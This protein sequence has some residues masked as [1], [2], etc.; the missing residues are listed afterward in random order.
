MSIVA[1]KIDGEKITLAGDT[2]S[3]WGVHKLPKADYSD[4][5]VKCFGKIFQVNDMTIGC[6]GSVADIGLLRLYCK[7]HRPKEMERDYVLDWF[8]E[9]RDWANSKYKVNINDLSIHGILVYNKKAYTF[10]DFLDVVEVKSCDAVGSGMW[11][12][13]GAMFTGASAEEAVKAAIRYDMYCGGDV[14]KIEL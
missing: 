4:K 12:A 14:T 11:L 13:L 5:N 8:V 7:T 6:A 2:Q 3:S 1:V 10:Y 9:F